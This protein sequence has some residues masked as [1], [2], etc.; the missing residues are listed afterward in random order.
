M[1]N[2]NIERIITN[3]VET[4]WRAEGISWN[5]ATFNICSQR[6][7]IREEK[8]LIVVYLDVSKIMAEPYQKEAV[9]QKLKDEIV[10]RFEILE[11][12]THGSFEVITLKRK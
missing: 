12:T 3:L 2:E 9:I 5:N 4:V 10:I 7:V 11:T 1:E 8:D 6:I